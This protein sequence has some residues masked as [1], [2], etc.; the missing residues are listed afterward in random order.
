MCQNCIT[1]EQNR[2]EDI[3]QLCLLSLLEVG[4]HFLLKKYIDSIKY[5]RVGKKIKKL[6]Q[7]D[8]YYGTYIKFLLNRTIR[9][10][11]YLLSCDGAYG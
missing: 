2:V 11:H 9:I 3:K 7:D 5:R 4:S 8:Y 1:L 10:L 6:I